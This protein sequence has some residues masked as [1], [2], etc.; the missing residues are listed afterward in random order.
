MKPRNRAAG[1]GREEH[2]DD[3]E[4]PRIGNAVPQRG[5]LRDHVVPVEQQYE[6]DP[7][8]HEQ[9]GKAENRIDPADDLVDRQ[10][11]RRNIIKKNHPQH[12]QQQPRETV[13]G[14]NVQRRDIQS[15]GD[16]RGGLRKENCSHKDHQPCGKQAHDDFHAG[17]QIASH[18]FG[19]ARAILTQRNDAGD[20]VVH[21]T[22]EDPAQRDPQESHG[23]VCRAENRT[24]DRAQTGDIEQLD[25]KNPPAWKRNVIHAVIK[26]VA[27]R[28][29][30][31]VDADQPLQITAIGK[32]G[33]DEQRQTYQKSDH[34]KN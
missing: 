9:Q 4:I 27:G 8:R 2:R 16:Q 22:H 31:R 11:R 30:R 21:G 33:R 28:C 1:N 5:Q 7:E 18:Q 19:E 3:R 29:R 34:S 15:V 24:E 26:A 20:E 14:R 25:E 10:Q 6:E 32:I 17:A 23:T 13:E 12:D